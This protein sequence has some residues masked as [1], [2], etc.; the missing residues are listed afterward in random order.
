[1]DVVGHLL[2]ALRGHAHLPV[3]AEVYLDGDDAVVVDWRGC[4]A[5]AYVRSRP[6]LTGESHVTYKWMH[7]SPR[8]VSSRGH[9]FFPEGREWSPAG[10]EGLDGLAGRM[11]RTLWPC[12]DYRD[13]TQG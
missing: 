3:G 4:R 5:Q 2:G 7:G 8:G 12:M 10:P 13:R 6:R 9:V 11:A 1:M